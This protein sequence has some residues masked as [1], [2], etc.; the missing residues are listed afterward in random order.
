MVSWPPEWPQE[1]SIK[2]WGM[3]NQD[4]PLISI[5]FAFMS[6]FPASVNTIDTD[7]FGQLSGN[8]WLAKGTMYIL[9]RMITNQ[10]YRDRI[11]IA[12]V[13]D[14]KFLVQHNMPSHP[15]VID[16]Q[17]LAQYQDSTLHKQR[18]PPTFSCIEH[19]W[20]LAPYISYRF[21]R[22]TGRPVE[23]HVRQDELNAMW[24]PQRP[25]A[26]ISTNGN[27]TK[28][29]LLFPFCIKILMKFCIYLHFLFISYLWLTFWEWICNENWRFRM[30]GALSMQAVYVKIRMKRSDLIS[31]ALN[32]NAHC[33]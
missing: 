27:H 7:Q 26:Y 14:Q 4:S 22:S 16:I 9:N 17:C 28:F 15:A 23:L 18:D 12:S 1:Q 24:M 20:D 13:Q 3:T 32:W 5:T 29:L 31:S 21:Q 30:P 19:A 11:V 2:W 25:R 10:P 33:S 8:V 6:R